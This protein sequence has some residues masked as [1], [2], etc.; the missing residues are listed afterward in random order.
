MSMIWP[1]GPIERSCLSWAAKSSREKVSSR[2]FLASAS[3]CACVH[4]GLGLL[5]QREH[6]A[7]AEDALGQPVGVERLERVGLLADADER[8][9]PSR[10]LAHRQRRAAAGVAVHLGEDHRVDAD[11]GVEL[12]G[13]RRPRPGRSWRPPRAARGAGATSFLIARS[14]SSISSSMCSRPAVSRMSGES[15]RRAA[16]SRAPRADRHRL[17]RP[18]SPTHGD[19]ELLAERLELVDRRRGGR[20]RREASR[21]CWPCFWK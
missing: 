11:R 1:S 2:I 9:G 20:R 8:D 21:G 15:P 17:L 10:H 16:S 12:L 7:H 18:R 5:D 6:V 4:R 3:A 14:S 19:A 13:H